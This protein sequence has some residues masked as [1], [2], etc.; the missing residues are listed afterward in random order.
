MIA[1]HR[2]LKYESIPFIV[3]SF[4]GQLSLMNPSTLY[5]YKNIFY[6]NV[7][8]EICEILRTL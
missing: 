7:E 3:L 1:F 8:A 4:Q 6:K 2:Q 5:F